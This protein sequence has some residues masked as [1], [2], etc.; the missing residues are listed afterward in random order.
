MDLTGWVPQSGG[1]YDSRHDAFPL[2]AEEVTVE[3]VLRVMDDN[4]SFT[5]IFNGKFVG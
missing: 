5:C 3:K 2:A 1:A 4:V